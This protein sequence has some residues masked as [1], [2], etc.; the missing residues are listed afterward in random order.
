MKTAVYV[1]LA[2]LLVCLLIPAT[3][4]GNAGTFTVAEPNPEATAEDYEGNWV[5]TYADIGGRLFEAE[6]DLE[7]LGMDS[8]LTLKIENGTAA[9]TGLAELGTDPL[10]LTFS[11]GNMCFMPEENVTVFTL[12]LLQDG[13]V[14]MNFN[15]I[16]FGP[17]LYLFPSEA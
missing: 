12:R 1:F 9:F 2:L 14:S 11:E 5:C 13:T 15:M 3:A 6:S 10:P 17:T 4:E 16:E 7:L 8:L